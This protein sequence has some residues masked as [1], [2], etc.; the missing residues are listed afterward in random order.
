MSDFSQNGIISTLHDFGTKST[1]QI[2]KELLHFSKETLFTN[3]LKSQPKIQLHNK[4][5]IFTE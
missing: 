4:S 1:T 3:Q 2:E 5:I